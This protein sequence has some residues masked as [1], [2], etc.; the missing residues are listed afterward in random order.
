MTDR[1]NANVE[2][3]EYVRALRRRWLWL[4]A[5]VVAAMGIATGLTLTADPSYR[6]QTVLY[7]STGTGDP[8]ARAT[9]INSYI[10]LLTGPR[11]AESVIADLGLPMSTDA[12][13]ESIT[14]Q[15]QEGTDLLT[16]SA[17]DSSA[18]RSRS[19]V[20]TAT[21]AL[22]DL[23]EELDPPVPATGESP[24]GPSPSTT[25]AGRRTC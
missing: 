23:A 24:A 6:S 16:V 8:D 12:V 14:A 19:I 20:T 21:A 15:V 17:T 10:A 9:R 1:E 22:L 2:L 25:A 13:R 3:R 4:V 7:V 5:P 18:E 11:V